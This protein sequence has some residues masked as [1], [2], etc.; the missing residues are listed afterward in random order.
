MSLMDNKY[1]VHIASEIVVLIGLTFYFNQKNK[2]MMN[3]IEDLVQRVEEQE[4]IL[5]KHEQ[6]IKKL[7]G[8]INQLSS[9][10][11]N[12]SLPLHKQAPIKQPSINP[13]SSIKISFKENSK[14]NK[15]ENS[16]KNN[17][18]ILNENE[19]TNENKESENEEISENEE[20]LDK[21]LDEELD[22]LKN[23][24]NEE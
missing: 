2:K 16:K 17:I 21:E 14:N 23:S 5:Q 19:E 3:Y 4:D 15:V 8:Y 11:Y 20:D 22:E 7:I 18:E 12:T 1:M 6:L 13:K 24:L 9:Q 10:P